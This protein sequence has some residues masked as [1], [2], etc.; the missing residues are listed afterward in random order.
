MPTE[1]GAAIAAVLVVVAAW[2]R[3]ELDARRERLERE[4]LS[5]RVEDVQHKVGSDRRRSDV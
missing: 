3:L 4:R 5:Q 2:L 1:L